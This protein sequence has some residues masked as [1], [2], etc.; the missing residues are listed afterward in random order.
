MTEP[1][2][3]S[4]REE[5]RAVN[6]SQTFFEEHDL[7]FQEVDLRNDIG[8]DAILDLSRSG[9]DAGLCI[10]LQ[11]CSWRVASM[12]PIPIAI[13]RLRNFSRSPSVPTYSSLA[14]SH[15]TIPRTG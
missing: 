10:A 3:I 4:R 11:T 13:A 6:V 7:I 14:G 12:I 1:S 5:R 8:K 2:N 15:T 9:D